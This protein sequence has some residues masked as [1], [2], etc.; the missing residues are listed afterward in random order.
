MIEQLTGFADNVVAFHCL[1]RVTKAD[2]ISVLVPT[3]TEALRAQRKVRL[4]YETGPDFSLDPRAAWEDFK[5]GMES[6]TRW[7]RVAVV[8]DI[9]W[10][11]HAVQLFGFLMPG[12]TKLFSANEA[13]QAR[14]WVCS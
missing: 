12:V 10:I 8:T 3:V 14:A 7:E 6:V 11:K 5:V 1:G 9:G 13:E 2:Y 4:Y